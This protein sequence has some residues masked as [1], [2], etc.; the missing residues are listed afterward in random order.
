VEFQP[1]INNDE[2]KMCKTKENEITKQNVCNSYEWTARG[3]TVVVKTSTVTHR[4][5]FADWLGI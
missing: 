3:S 4:I 5:E 2:A 1:P